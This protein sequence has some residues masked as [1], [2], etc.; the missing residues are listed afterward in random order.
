MFECSLDGALGIDVHQA[1]VL[2]PTRSRI[3]QRTDV[4]KPPEIAG[5]C[6][7]RTV[8]EILYY[9]SALMETLQ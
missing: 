6:R 4:G 2:V 9:S 5:N 3:D 1:V 7:Q 8:R